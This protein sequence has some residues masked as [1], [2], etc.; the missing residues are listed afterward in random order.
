MRRWTARIIGWLWNTIGLGLALV[1]AFH[2]GQWAG[3]GRGARDIARLMIEMR[4]AGDTIDEPW[5]HGGI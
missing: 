3:Y 1:L 4:Q 2:I 5:D